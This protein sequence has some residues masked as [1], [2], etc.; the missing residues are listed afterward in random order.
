ML[1]VDRTAFIGGAYVSGILSMI[2]CMCF[3]L[4]SVLSILQLAMIS[5]R[6]EVVLKYKTCVI[7]KLVLSITAGKSNIFQYFNS[8]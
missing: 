6:D 1:T 3:A 5:S 4:F 8:R 2:S 7:S